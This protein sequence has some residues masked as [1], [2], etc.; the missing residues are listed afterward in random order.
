MAEL[1]YHVLDG[2]RCDASV[3]DEVI[4]LPQPMHWHEG[5]PA[6]EKLAKPLGWSLWVSRTRRTYCPAHGPRPGSKL[7]KVW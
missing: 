2:A 3:C 5:M 1:I 7:R 6:L 4:L